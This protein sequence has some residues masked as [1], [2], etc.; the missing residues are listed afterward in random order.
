MPQFDE[1]TRDLISFV[2][3][4][5]LGGIRIFHNF[6]WAEKFERRTFRNGL[7]LAS[8]VKSDCPA[9]S[10]ASLIL[11]SGPTVSEGIISEP[12]NYALVINID[13]YMVRATPDAAAAYFT[14]RRSADTRLEITN[15]LARDSALRDEV[16]INNLTASYVM[17]WMG[18]NSSRIEQIR[19]LLSQAEVQTPAENSAVADPSMIIELLNR[20]DSI[21]ET[22]IST[23]LAV[24]TRLAVASTEHQNTLLQLILGT[25]E[26]RNI[27]AIELGGRIAER[28]QDIRDALRVYEALIN[29]PTTTETDTHE[30][31]IENPWLLGSDYIATRHEQPLSRGRVDCFLEKFDGHHDLMELKSPNH[32]IV[33]STSE[34]TTASSPTQFRLSPELS[35][36]IAQVNRYLFILDRDNQFLVN[37]YGMQNTKHPK[38]FILIGKSSSCSQSEIETLQQLN[39]SLHRIEILPFDTLIVKCDAMLAYLE[40]TIGAMELQSAESS[41]YEE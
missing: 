11:L 38:A 21:P 36:A 34:G 1:L 31:I 14:L 32:H 29:N 35:N 25:T 6:Q 17:Q 4:T 10:I 24:L 37:E 26:G 2:G 9:G 3:G 41:V 13:S 27:A 28:I 7:R 40:R 5:K 16:V 22:L 8:L 19:T 39:K 33:L 30:F 23:M 12:P 18:A 15:V 20:L